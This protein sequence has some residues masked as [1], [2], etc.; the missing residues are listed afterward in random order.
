MKWLSALTSLLL[1]L[2]ANKALGQEV[3]RC[4]TIGPDVLES[5]PFTT[6]KTFSV[7][8]IPVFFHVI[9]DDDTGE[10]GRVSSSTI[11]T[12]LDSLNHGF[13]DTN[14]TF[15]LAGISWT[16]SSYLFSN[17]WIVIPTGETQA[18]R[19]AKALLNVD[20][21][22][23]LNIYVTGDNMGALGYAT[24]PWSYSEDDYRHGVVI[25]YRSLPGVHSWDFDE[26]NTAVHEVGHYLGLLHTFH[27]DGLCTPGDGVADTNTQ[28]DANFSATSSSSCGSSDPVENYMDYSFDDIMYDFTSGQDSRMISY[29][30]QDKPSLGSS[31]IDLSARSFPDISTW[32]FYNGYDI[33]PGTTFELGDEVE[34]YFKSDIEIAGSSNSPI[35]F[36]PDGSSVWNN[37]WFQNTADIEYTVFDGGTV[38]VESFNSD[39]E[40]TYATLRNSEYDG[41]H[42]FSSGLFG[43]EGVTARRVQIYDNGRY[44]IFG[45]DAYIDAGTSSSSGQNS[46]FG[47]GSH[48]VHAYDMATVDARGNWWGQNPPSAGHFYEGSNSSVDYAGYLSSNPNTGGFFS[49][50]NGGN[51]AD[52]S[53]HMEYASYDRELAPE[54]VNLLLEITRKDEEG[55]LARLGE[56]ARVLNARVAS[57]QL[58]RLQ[59]RYA[60][61]L[62]F[63]A[64]ATRLGMRDEARALLPSLKGDPSYPLFARAVGLRDANEP[65]VDT[66]VQQN[67]EGYVTVENHPNPFNP[68]TM[69]SYDIPKAGHVTVTVH[70]VT[71]RELLTLANE[72]VPAGKHTIYFDASELSSGMYL[73]RV[74]MHEYVATQ[75]LLLVK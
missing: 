32:W 44:G 39:V 75:R 14:F 42:V 49:Y 37:I 11:H 9:Y 12:Q 64:Y 55:H 46:I 73:C 61:N 56:T 23:V 52:A 28:R 25:Q 6:N 67:D 26:G 30:G 62:L 33:S 22:H 63:R 66:D 4:G 13:R 10:T 71:G 7:T 43:S 21:A 1:V 35:V 51:F 72:D 27:E 20:P 53:D 5:V 57:G 41:L 69:I 54:I 38:L 58:D 3:I 19:D 40:L 68:G 15:S 24:F 34:L 45:Y 47:N 65:F 18:G 16:E 74:Q 70:D 60:R 36:E 2:L 8:N 31:V 17:P 29:A 48:E 59:A 50:K